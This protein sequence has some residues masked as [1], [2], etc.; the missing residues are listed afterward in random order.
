MTYKA[1]GFDYNGVLYGV[2][3][4]RFS[5]SVASILAI[6]VEEFRDTYFHHNKV[7]NRG[8]ISEIELWQRILKELKKEDMF[9]QVMNFV[10]E[11]ERSAT[12][13]TNITQ[14]VD[15]L[16]SSGYKVGMLS[17]HT[18]KKADELR[19]LGFNKHFDEFH[20][21]SETGFVKPEPEAFIHLAE[22]LKV[23]PNE[24][25]F[26][27]DAKKSLSSAIDVGY[28]PIL[29]ESYGQLVKNLSELG[30]KIQ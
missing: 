16:R 26:V 9:G 3:A 27:D 21:S 15:N 11:S 18:K 25:I 17:N 4:S 23:Q 29:F 24:L 19:S 1:I 28:T 5:R 30:I 13:N 12:V 2:P 22:K 8:N 7:F 20:V 10:H 6:T 14:L